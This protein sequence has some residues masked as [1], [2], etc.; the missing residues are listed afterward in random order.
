MSIDAWI[1]D[2]A[3]YWVRGDVQVAA[4]SMGTQAITLAERIPA[5][6]SRKSNLE[7]LTGVR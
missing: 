7:R 5:L 1:P 3:P 4:Q 6:K 2:D